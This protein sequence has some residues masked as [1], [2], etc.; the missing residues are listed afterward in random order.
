MTNAAVKCW[1]AIRG[2]VANAAIAAFVFA[3]MSLA[4]ADVDLSNFTSSTGVGSRKVDDQA[5]S[6]LTSM[7]MGI[8]VFLAG[9]CF[10]GIVMFVSALKALNK[11][12]REERDAP[13]AA[14]WGVGIGAAMTCIPI[15]IGLFANTLATA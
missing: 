4:N 15:I 5:S 1:N 12:K 14:S 8:K 9:C 2:C 7:N 11:A 13:P 10:V 3:Q 6:W